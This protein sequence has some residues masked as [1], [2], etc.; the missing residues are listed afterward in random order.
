MNKLLLSLILLSTATLAEDFEQFLDKAIK[1]SPYL[2]SSALV[3]EQKKEEGGMLTR[4]ANPNLELEYS[5]F[6][7]SI[8]SSD[9]G[10]RVS[11]SQPIRLWS[12]GDDK[13]ALVEANVHNANA[14]Y[15]QKRALFVR[16]IS[17]SYSS[18]LQSKQLVA[19]G[20]QELQI[21]KIIYDISLARFESGS[22]SEGLKLQAQVDYEMID[23]LQDNLALSST[24]IYYKLLKIAGINEE[25]ELDDAYDFKIINSAKNLQ[26]PSIAV[27]KTQQN[28]A[29]KSAKLNSNAIEWVNLFAELENEPDQ[30][31]YRAGVNIPLAIFNNKSEEKSIAILQA[32][33]SELL[34][35]NEQS[36]LNIEITRLQRERQSLIKL[37]EKSKNILKTQLRL[38]KMY[39]DGYKIA[40]TSLLQL[41]DIKTKVIL[42]KKMIIKTN[43][44][45]NQN[46]IYTN[47]NQGNYNE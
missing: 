35:K 40:N 41:Q 18:Y 45:L 15:S 26:N 44:A 7:P 34:I 21:A 3:V 12:V 42:T 38:L 33:R 9:N 43:T 14:N 8:G 4:Y 13:E 24:N 22:I 31:I 23:N 29:L 20:Q 25:I 10:Y 47:Y 39:E 36:R 28:Q 27:I 17:L 11:Y 19:L 37:N 5:S 16:D 46:A 1:Q 6:Q 2:K 32:T 30:N